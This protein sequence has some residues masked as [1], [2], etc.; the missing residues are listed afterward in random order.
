MSRSTR[1]HLVALTA[2]L[3]AAC[4]TPRPLMLGHSMDEVVLPKLTGG[5][6]SLDELRGQ[7]VLVDVWAS[8]CRPCVQSLPFYAD[9]ENALSAKGFRFVGINID[10]DR[11]A[12]AAFLK[13][14][15]LSV[16]T[17]LDPGA[18]LIAP[19]FKITRMPTAFLLD[20]AGNIR[21]VHE[22]FASADKAKWREEIE[23][24]LAEPHP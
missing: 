18:K 7:V 3:A 14:E 22:G 17:L 24:L 20:R 23:A 13:E 1:L 12:A 5:T 6:R 2:S 4:V 16:E 8:W 9:L 15:S 19:R 11:R 10:E 21:H